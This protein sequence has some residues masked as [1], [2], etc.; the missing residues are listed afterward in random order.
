MRRRMK[1]NIFSSIN[2]LEDSSS[3]S[4]WNKFLGST[5]FQLLILVLTFYALFFDDYQVL[6]CRK[7]SNTMFDVI[8]CLAIFIFIV[9]LTIASIHT[10]GY[11]NSYYFYLDIISALSIIIDLNFVTNAMTYIG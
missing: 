11:C 3:Q 10:R 2:K 4:K 8:S 6:I 7:Y 5:Y 1:S 9:E